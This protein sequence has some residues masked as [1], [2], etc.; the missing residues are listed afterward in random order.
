MS[1]EQFTRYFQYNKYSQCVKYDRKK[2]HSIRLQ[3]KQ[4]IGDFY[5]TVVNLRTILEVA[6][7][8]IIAGLP[9][10]LAF[11]VR[12]GRPIDLAHALESALSTACDYR[13]SDSLVML[14]PTP[15]PETHTAIHMVAVT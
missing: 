5:A 10:Q 14:Q 2:S 3:P 1:L 9:D 8:D 7:R 13:E 12:A 4:R 11:F 15:A 6:G